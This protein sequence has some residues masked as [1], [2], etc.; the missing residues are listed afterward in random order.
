MYD[1]IMADKDMLH[2]L[3]KE[4]EEIKIF[5]IGNTPKQDSCEETNDTCLQDSMRKNS[6]TIDRCLGIT[7][8]IKDAIR[9]GKE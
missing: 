3:E 9:G 1:L 4:L 8:I 5:L 7:F 6:Q 2:K